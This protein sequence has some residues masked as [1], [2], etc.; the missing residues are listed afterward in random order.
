MKIVVIKLYVA[1]NKIKYIVYI[2]YENENY[3]ML[4]NMFKANHIFM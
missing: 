1:Y 2:L 4:Q 3:L